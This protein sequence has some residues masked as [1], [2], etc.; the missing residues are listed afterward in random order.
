MRIVEG[1]QVWSPGEESSFH[2]EQ[3][4]IP[5]G[6][7]PERWWKGTRRWNPSIIIFLKNSVIHL[8]L[9]S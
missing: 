3:K 2:T 6:E 1:T 5:E 9:C 4:G 8:F 7:I